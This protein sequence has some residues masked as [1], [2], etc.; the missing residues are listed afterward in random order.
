M[1]WTFLILSCLLLLTA[2][3]LNIIDKYAVMHYHSTRGGLGLAGFAVGIIL[4][5]WYAILAITLTVFIVTA[6]KMVKAKRQ[7]KDDCMKK[8][9]STRKKIFKI[10]GIIITAMIV[11][12]YFCVYLDGLPKEHYLYWFPFRMYSG[13]CGSV[14]AIVYLVLIYL[15]CK[16]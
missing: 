14:G 13:I 11:Y 16:D 2:P 3:L 4:I 8:K 12:L 6:I 9:V 1:K 10:A 5:F 15:M 7:S